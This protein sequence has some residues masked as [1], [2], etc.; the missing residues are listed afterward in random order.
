VH[1]AVPGAIATPSFPQPAFAATGSFPNLLVW[2]PNL[3]PFDNLL[4]GQAM[5]ALMRLGYGMLLRK[6]FRRHHEVVARPGLSA[7]HGYD[8]ENRP[9]PRLHAHS[10]HLV[11]KP[12]VW[13]MMIK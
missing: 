9:V 1:C 10:N 8:P 5:S 4:S 3:G 6:W 12:P 13:A 11:P 7:V 2:L